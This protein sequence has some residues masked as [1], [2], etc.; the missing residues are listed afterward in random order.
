VKSGAIVLLHLAQPVEKFWGALVSLEPVG[1]VLRGINLNSF[2]D[3]LVELAGG[4]AQDLGLVT[5]FVPMTRVERMF[6]DE[7][8][9]EVESYRERVERRLGRDL[10]GWLV[11]APQRP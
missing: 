4:D 3:W 1:V 9:G 8:V 5:M 10:E 6:L 11:L 7:R 2:D